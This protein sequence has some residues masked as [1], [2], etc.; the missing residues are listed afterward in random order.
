LPGTGKLN[1]FIF[2][3]NGA[4]SNGVLILC[5]VTD[6]CRSDE[7]VRLQRICTP[8]NPVFGR[9]LES[10]DWKSVVEGKRVQIRR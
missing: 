6:F 10:R 4:L 9:F 1:T 2:S 7:V 3:E 8:S 5:A